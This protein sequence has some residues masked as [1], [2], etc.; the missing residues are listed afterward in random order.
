V[1]EGCAGGRRA[2]GGGGW[3]W[4]GLAGGTDGAAW[5]GRCC[6]A[7]A[8]WLGGRACWGDARQGRPYGPEGAAG[9][10]ALGAISGSKNCSPARPRS[11]PPLPSCTR[12][13]SPPTCLPRLAAHVPQRLTRSLHRPPLLPPPQGNIRR[14]LRYLIPAKMLLGELPSDRLLERYALQEYRDLK[15]ALQTGDV[16]LLNRAL[17]VSGVGEGRGWPRGMRRCCSGS[18]CLQ[19]CEARARAWI[20]AGPQRRG[21][22]AAAAVK[23]TRHLA[24]PRSVAGARQRSDA[25]PPPTPRPAC[26]PTSCASSAP[27]PT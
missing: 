19:G 15:A 14:I 11:L 8:W 9:R 21:D 2:A 24:Q 12:C 4:Q 18:A 6:C 17:Q 27:A 7:G 10:S 3:G 20:A 25:P 13:A 16:G 22:Q 26:R 1:Q 5:C 23:E